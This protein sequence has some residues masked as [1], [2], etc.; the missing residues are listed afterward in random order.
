MSK[1]F[2]IGLPKAIR[3]QVE[4]AARVHNI[5]IKSVLADKGERAGSLRLVPYPERAIEELRAYADEYEN[6]S[7]A[8]VL[9][10]PYAKLPPD[11]NEELDAFEALGGFVERVH[12]GQNGWEKFPKTQLD[13]SFYDS[14]FR[15]I[16]QNL[17]PQDELTPSEYFQE[18]ALRNNQF[19][20]PEGALNCCDEVADH[21]YEFLKDVADALQKYVINGGSNGRIDAYFNDLGIEHAQTGGINAT[22]RVFE[23]G[24]CVHNHTSNTHLKKGDNTSRIA[25]ARVYYQSFIHNDRLYVA[26]LYAGPHPENDIDFSVN[27]N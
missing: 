18:I 21:R 27:L 7:D 17:F 12:Q 14:V 16:T 9:V 1:V 11:L 10:L 19:L 13:K 23:H 6:F 20:I 3:G 5:S 2:I 22:L 15:S 4:A 24:T 8:S 26:V 25:A